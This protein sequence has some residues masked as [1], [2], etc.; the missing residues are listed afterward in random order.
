MILSP[1]ALLLV[2]F[3]SGNALRTG[4]HIHDLF[5]THIYIMRA[6]M[7]VRF[8]PILPELAPR[9]NSNGEAA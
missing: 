2:A 1:I 9:R 5:V 3:E 4:A 7:R 6:R 8:I